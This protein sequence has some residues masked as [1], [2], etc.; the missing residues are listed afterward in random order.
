L[1]RAEARRCN[2]GQLYRGEDPEDL[3]QWLKNHRLDFQ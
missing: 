2:G 1:A 3:P